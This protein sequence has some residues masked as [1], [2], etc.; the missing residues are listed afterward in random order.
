M[1]DIDEYESFLTSKIASWTP[2]QRLAFAAAMAERWLHVYEKFSTTEKWGD[3]ASLRQSL[4]AV[5]TQVMG[6]NLG[7]A[8]VARHLKQLE[9]CTP[10]MDDFDAYEALAACII[11]NEALEACGSSEH[12]APVVRAALSGFEAAVENWAFNPEEQP[13]LWKKIAARN[14]LKKQLKLIERISAITQF[15]PSNVAMLR[16]SITGAE[17]IGRVSL[18]KRPSAAELTNQLAFEQYRRM[19]ENQLKEKPREPPPGIP[20]AFAVKFVTPW[21]ARYSR[22][23]QTI[24]GSYGRLADTLGQQALM[25]HYRAADFNIPA[26]ADWAGDTRRYIDLIYGNAASTIDV[27][28]PEEAHSYGPSLRRLW[29]EAKQRG[30]SDNE[31]AEAIVSWARHHPPVWKMEDLRKK[32]GLAHPNL[33]IGPHLAREITWNWTD[34]PHH[35]WSADVGGEN[36]RV[37]INDFPDDLMYTLIIG[38]DEIASFHDWPQSWRRS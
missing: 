15:D 2:P 1:K 19:M 24:D 4:D 23:R 6:Q 8:E 36:W 27:H 34:N 21:S 20:F 38:E 10:H 31:S 3:P 26:S 13:R 28:A 29:V 32:K 9:D 16:R 7:T 11:L 18:P 35:P 33:A 17:F 14:E 37:R 12:T 25:A 5:W 22:R 30:A